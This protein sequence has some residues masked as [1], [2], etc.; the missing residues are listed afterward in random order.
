MAKISF[1]C[2]TPTNR[3]VFHILDLNIDNSSFKLESTDDAALKLN[4]K[5]ENDFSRQFFI[6]NF[7]GTCKK[8]AN[9]VLSLK[10]IGLISEDLAGFYRSS[11]INPATNKKE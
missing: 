3:I 2:V 11:Y 6:M 10:Y 5:W 8:D 1:K 7:T 4:D 9:Y